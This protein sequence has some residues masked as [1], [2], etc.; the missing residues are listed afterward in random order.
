[1]YNYSLKIVLS[2]F[3][4][5]SG[6][7]H[8]VCILIASNR[9]VYYYDSV[10]PTHLANAT[11]LQIA[12]IM[13]TNDSFIRVIRVPVQQ[14]EGSKDCGLFAVAF[15]VAACMGRELSKVSFDQK[16]MR[17]HLVSCIESKK[18][19]AFPERKVRH[20]CSKESTVIIDVH[21][22]CRMPECFDD[23][24]IECE[25]CLSW[26]HY[27]CVTVIDEDGWKCNNCSALK[28]NS[29]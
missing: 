7:S 22:S 29:S 21:C 15:A 9:E 11:I 3:L 4:L 12:N 16:K 5:I 18:M 25:C 20:S 8:W 17:Q 19:I 10:A 2:K 27:K 14:Q 6:T 24:M 1:M 13:H 23:K 28:I 26:Y